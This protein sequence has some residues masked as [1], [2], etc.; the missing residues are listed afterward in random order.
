ML[1]SGGLWTGF[2]PRVRT[3]IAARKADLVSTCY[4]AAGNVDRVRKA[5]FVESL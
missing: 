5:G 1:R 2:S 3:L 4:M